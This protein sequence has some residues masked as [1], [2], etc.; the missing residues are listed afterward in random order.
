MKK[1]DSTMSLALC[2]T[3]YSSEQFEVLTADF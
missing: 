1:Q 3:Y 2:A